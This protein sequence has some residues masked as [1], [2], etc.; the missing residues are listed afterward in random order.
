MALNEHGKIEQFDSTPAPIATISDISKAHGYPPLQKEQ[1]RLQVGQEP[2][3]HSPIGGDGHL[4]PAG[5]EYLKVDTVSTNKN[6][7]LVVKKQMKKQAHTFLDE[8]SSVMKQRAELRDAADGE[9][10]MECIVK[11]FNA[12]TGRNLTTA[13]GWEFM[14]LLKMVRGRQGKFNADDYV[15]GAAYFSL[16]GENESE[17]RNKG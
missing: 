16:L 13:E 8:A 5:V 10:S 1:R 4:I 17:S 2:K 12:L 11:T 3:A 6:E 9:R 7:T 15:D 14:I